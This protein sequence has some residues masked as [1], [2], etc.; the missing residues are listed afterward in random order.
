MTAVRELIFAAIESRLTG[1]EGVSLVE[2]MPS[3][4]PDVFPALSIF[5]GGQEPTDQGCSATR[6]GLSVTIEGYVE[7]A[8]GPEAHAALSQLYVDTVAALMTEPPLGG[9]VEEIQE[10]GFRPS[11]AHLAAAK[12][13]AFGLDFTVL[14]STARDNPALPA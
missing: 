14:F 12:R 5:D 1:V 10:G 6:H 13:L 11:V 8:D 3:G 9:L 4:D 2:R 7:G